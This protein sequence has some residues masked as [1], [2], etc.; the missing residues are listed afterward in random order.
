MYIP[1]FVYSCFPYNC[2][3]V[4]IEK[5]EDVKWDEKENEIRE[6]ESLPIEK[7]RNSMSILIR[8]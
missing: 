1:V 2:V 4:G 6:S 5:E 3:I 7:M 8:N